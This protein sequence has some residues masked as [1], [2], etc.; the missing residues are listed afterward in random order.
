MANLTI[1]FGLCFSV[2]IKNMSALIPA[3][4]SAVLI[5]GGAYIEFNSLP[6]PYVTKFCLALV[7]IGYLVWG[8]YYR[9]KARVRPDK[10]GKARFLIFIG[11]FDLA[12]CYL[13][14]MQNWPLDFDQYGL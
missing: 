6:Y 11:L 13:V 14:N 7:G 2:M 1:V 5:F 12:A 10:R 4:G 8:V 3:A 9:I